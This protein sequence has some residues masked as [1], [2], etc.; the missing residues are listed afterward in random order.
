MA[1]KKIKKAS[2]ASAASE[3]TGLATL[4][5]ASMPAFMQRNEGTTGM[6][7]MSGESTA[8]RIQLAQG[9][10]PQVNRADQQYIE[11]LQAGEFFNALTGENLG[12][13]FD[14]YI[15]K[16]YPSRALF[17][18]DNEVDCFSADSVHGSKHSPLCKDCPFGGWGTDRTP[19]ECKTFENLVVLPEGAEVPAILGIKQSNKHATAATRNL[20]THLRLHGHAGTYAAKYRFTARSASN[21]KKQSFYITTAQPVGYVEGEALYNRLA[22]MAETFANINQQKGG[23]DGE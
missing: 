11:G 21:A 3:G 1:I 12:E 23:G 22:A 8:P 13:S 18:E 7:D 6:E 2:E 9:L 10:S 15:L 20:R 14:G 5:R 16:V 4:P 17:T 19:P